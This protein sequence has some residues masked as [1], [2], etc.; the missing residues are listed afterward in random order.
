LEVEFVDLGVGLDDLLGEI[1][2][3]GFEG[4]ESPAEAVGD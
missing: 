3:F 1:G 4:V 2:V